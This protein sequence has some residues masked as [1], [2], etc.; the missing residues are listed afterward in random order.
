MQHFILLIYCYRSAPPSSFPNLDG[1]PTFPVHQP[2]NN[3]Q[4]IPFPFD[5]MKLL[6]KCQQVEI[7]F[8]TFIQ[9]TYKHIFCTFLYLMYG[10]KFK[11]ANSHAW[12]YI[13]N[14]DMYYYKVT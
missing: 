5:L 7:L 2:D 11:K 13:N 9:G 12:Q 6:P 14:L 1:P 8:S 10:F 4:V 3:I